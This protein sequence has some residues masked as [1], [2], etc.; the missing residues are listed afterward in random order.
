MF[1]SCVKRVKSNDSITSCL[2]AQKKFF[3][4]EIINFVCVESS[5]NDFSCAP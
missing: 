3:L 2:D 1:C 5:S 4:A